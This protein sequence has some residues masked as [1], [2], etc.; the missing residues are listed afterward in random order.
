MVAATARTRR[1]RRARPTGP[2]RARPTSPTPVAWAPRSRAHWP[3]PRRAP[4]QAWPPRATRRPT[5][6]WPRRCPS[7]SSVA[8]TSRTRSGATIRA[9]A[10]RARSTRSAT[11][12]ERRSASEILHLQMPG[13]PDQRAMVRGLAVLYAAGATLVA[14]TVA[15][16]H[17]D[18]E[19]TVALLVPVGVAYLVV[20]GLLVGA[21]RLG[22]P[23]LHATMATGTLLVAVCVVLAGGAGGAYAF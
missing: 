8:S 16:P 11:A 3:R 10:A 19:Q 9:G 14:L 13:S 18:N 4:A 15:L 23:V 1:P 12:L 2:R 22:E 17:G 20:A 21:D 7:S 5:A 6:R